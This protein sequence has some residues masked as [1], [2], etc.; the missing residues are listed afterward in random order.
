MV[1]P[2][3]G[4]TL[5]WLGVFISAQYLLQ[6]TMEERSSKVMEVLLSAVSPMHLMSGKIIGLGLVGFVLTGV[7]GGTIGVGLMFAAMSDLIRWSSLFLFCLYYLMA[8]LVMGSMFAAIGSA[9]TEL[10]EAQSL[11]TPGVL[12]MTVPFLL[13]VP[14]MSEP[15]GSMAVWMSYVPLLTPFVMSFRVLSTD[16]VPWLQ[17]ITTLIWGYMWAVACVWASAKVF[18]VGVL[19][20]GKAPTITELA[21]WVFED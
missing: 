17:V 7:Y 20:Q 10:R 2:L 16:P 14:M 5:T 18:R 12:L 15:N 6:N 1:I 11:M 8:Y 13:I 9:V 19:M 3:L 21:R 4:L